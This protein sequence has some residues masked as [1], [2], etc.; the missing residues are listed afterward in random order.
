[1]TPIHQRIVDEVVERM[2]QRVQE[3]LRACQP[4]S[5]M[6][7]ASPTREQLR[8]TLLGQ[9]LAAIAHYVEGYSYPIEGDVRTSASFVARCLY[10]DPLAP[11]GFRLPAKWQRTELGS[12]VHA[13]LLHFYEEERPG[14]LLTVTQMR[15]LFGVTRQTVH[16]WIEDG[17]IFAVYRGDTPLFYQK[18]VVR[19][20]QRRAQ[21]QH[22]VRKSRQEGV[23]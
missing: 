19:L 16:Q 17:V 6:P 8:Q 21:K 20:Q 10:G 11:Q 4:A 23:S 12:L 5:A 2:Y 13:A 22:R 15:T 9:H 18:D 7:L 1:M 3:L 14:N